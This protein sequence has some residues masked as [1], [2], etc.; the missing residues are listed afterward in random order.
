MNIK[1]QSRNDDL[2]I[3]LDPTLPEAYSYAAFKVG[4][5]NHIPELA[6]SLAQCGIMANSND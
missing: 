5:E 3:R 6:D 1:K 4:A 2:I